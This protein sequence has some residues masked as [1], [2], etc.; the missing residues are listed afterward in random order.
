MTENKK[1]ALFDAVIYLL[2]MHKFLYTQRK[3]DCGCDGDPIVAN[4]T[5]D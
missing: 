2:N 1:H 3:I 5:T 4:L